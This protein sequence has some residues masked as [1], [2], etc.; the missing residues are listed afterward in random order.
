MPFDDVDVFRSIADEEVIYIKRT[1]DIRSCRFDYSWLIA[2]RNI[3]RAINRNYNFYWIAALVLTIINHHHETNYILFSALSS[4]IQQSMNVTSNVPNTECTATILWVHKML[5]PLQ[6]RAH[7]QIRY[8]NVMWRMILS[9]Y[10]LTT[11]IRHI[12]TSRIFLQVGLTHICYI[13]NGCRFMKSALGISLLSTFCVSSINYSLVCSLPI[14]KRSSANAQGPLA[15]CQLKSYK[16]LY[17]CSTECIW[18][19]L[20]PRN[21]LQNHSRSL[22]LVPFDR[23]YT[24]SYKSSIACISL[25]CTVFEILTLIC[26]KK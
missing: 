12:C 22:R 24:I 2:I 23:P 21:N 16:M 13:T 14:H 18:K 20:K 26:Q 9:V 19:G 5:L 7:Q 11:E 4:Y 25:S 1:F 10:L 17:K 3:N 8:P 6:T 15:H